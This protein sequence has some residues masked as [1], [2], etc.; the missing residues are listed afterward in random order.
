MKILFL[1]LSDM[2]ITGKKSVNHNQI[3]KIINAINVVGNFDK[4]LIVLS[5]DCAF[6]GKAIEYTGVRRIVGNIISGIRAKFN[7]NDKINVITVPGN[8]DL[9]YDIGSLTVEDLNDIYSTNTYDK[10]LSAEISKLN[11]YFNFSKYNSCFSVESVYD[12]RIIE[13]NGFKIQ[14]DMLNSSLFS[15]KKGEDKGMHFIPEDALDEYGKNS[16]GDISVLVMHHAP[17]W[18]CDNIK[19]KLETIMRRKTSIAFLGHEHYPDYKQYLHDGNDAVLLLNGGTLCNKENWDNSSFFAGI[20]NTEDKT[21]RNWQFDWDMNSGIYKSKDIGLTTIVSKNSSKEFACKPD[22]MKE[23]LLDKKH[24]EQKNIFD[25]FV[26]P[27]LID[28]NGKEITELEQFIKK[29]DDEK[30]AFILGGYNSGRTIFLK[31]LFQNMQN[32]RFPLYIDANDISGS[33]IDRIIKN[34]FEEMYGED[35]VSYCRFLQ[36]DKEERILLIDNVDIIK[37]SQ[38]SAFIKY[39]RENFGYSIFTAKKYIEFDIYERMKDEID[40]SK[41]ISKYSIAPWYS[42][43]RK[44]L[45]KK[46]ASTELSSEVDIDSISDNLNISIK[47]QQ[48]YFNLNPDF[49]TQF[50]EY[51]CK[52]MSQ[53]Q[54]N[55]SSVFGKVFEANLISLVKEH[56]SGKITVDKM[57]TIL[58]IISYKTHKRKKYPIDETD[59]AQIIA[60]YNEEYGDTISSIDIINISVKSAIFIRESSENKYKFSNRNYLAYFIAKEINRK[61]NDDRDDSD[62]KTILNNACFGINADILLFLIYVTDNSRLLDLILNT[63]IMY[64]EEWEEYKFPCEEIKYLNGDISSYEISKIDEDDISNYEKEALEEEKAVVQSEIIKTLDIYDYCEDD[65]DK[66]INQLARAIN[67]LSIVSKCLPF[68][69]HNMKKD[70]KEA[71]VNLIYTL[72]NKIFYLWAINIEKEK[73]NVL[74]FIKATLPSDY[75][76]QRNIKES[77]DLTRDA[78]RILIDNSTSLLLD[79]YNMT[80]LNS[81][82]DNTIDYLSDFDYKKEDTYSIQHLM[83]LSN[84]NK[85]NDFINE[86]ERIIKKNERLLPTILVKKVS[87]H[88]LCSMKTKNRTL[89]ERL[90]QKVFPENAQQKS[91]LMTKKHIATQNE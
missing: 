72:P 59:I 73:G 61:Y 41:K 84:R 62:L 4:I 29:I 67:L 35:E 3:K 9:D 81:T 22:Y 1:H 86:A 5:G 28:E 42:D 37:S 19:H 50:V 76:K 66:M 68:F 69:E 30:Y 90:I 89:K 77:D 53:I 21:Y 58:A 55:D 20:L 54:N 7:Y 18:F 44:E 38:I 10:E 46:I 40:I 56:I 11:N 85:I 16:Q 48:T 12:C 57:L 60:E 71:F 34:A 24:I 78:L 88:A 26:F 49:I 23:F 25:R 6:S 14:F 87:N 80:T 65:V 79:I 43:K 39:I 33:R 27:R 32:F 52:N 8:H 2:H 45:I 15:I 47:S 70:R 17:E 31:Y 63:T 74:D 83:M 75:R 64:T 91:L 36:A 51:Y 13:F 82:K